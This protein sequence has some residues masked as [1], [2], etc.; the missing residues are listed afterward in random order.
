MAD[1]MPP[2]GPR[3]IVELLPDG[4]YK[5]EYYI[6][7]SRAIVPLNSAFEWVELQDKFQELKSIAD[8]HAAKKAERIAE[9]NASRHRQVWSSVANRHGIGFANK[10]V[11]AL[12]V[13]EAYKFGRYMTEEL[14]IKAKPEPKASPR[15]EELLA[16]LDD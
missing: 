15:P 6:N 12:P 5:M 2:A 4:R 14:L 8:N 10:T 3:I 11:N 7:G 13:A 9:A 16:L 1:N